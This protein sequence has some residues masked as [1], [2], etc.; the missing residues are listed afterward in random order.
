MNYLG[1]KH[2]GGSRSHRLTALSPYLEDV[3][4]VTADAAVAAQEAV[5]SLMLVANGVD[6]NIHAF[7]HPLGS[8]KTCSLQLWYQPDYSEAAALNAA[9][10]WSKFGTAVDLSQYNL[11]TTWSNLPQGRY[12]IQVSAISAATTISVY[13]AHTD[14]LTSY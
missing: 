2:H 9:T 13:E 8:G 4:A 14:D 10:A 6:N 12:K 1:N 3:E 5:I 7:V 11:H